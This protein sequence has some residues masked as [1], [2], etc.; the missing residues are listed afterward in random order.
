MSLK[1]DNNVSGLNYEH[2]EPVHAPDCVKGRKDTI[3]IPLCAT[4]NTA[5]CELDIAIVP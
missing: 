2:W 4:V 1:P 3:K 5:I